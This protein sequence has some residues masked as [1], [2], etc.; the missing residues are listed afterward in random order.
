[1]SHLR[2]QLDAARREYAA[3]RY[4]G[5]LGADLRRGE[6]RRTIGRI[7]LGASLAAAAIA[8]CVTIAVHIRSAGPGEPRSTAAITTPDVGTENEI[9]FSIESVP[10][11]GE[12][13]SPG[14]MA[15]TIE[16]IVPPAW[17]IVP[18]SD[19]LSSVDV[20]ESNSNPTTQE[21]A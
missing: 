10:S 9:S 16:S 12:V 18:T 11:W 1:M 3:T 13:E 5:E 7:F 14:S 21:A 17:S 6:A 8:A 4:P 19:T 20:N 15:P 2:E